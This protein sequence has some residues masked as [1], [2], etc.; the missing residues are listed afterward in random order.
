M[1][2][3]I[4]QEF[5]DS[6]LARVDIVDL[7]SE[8]IKLKRR[9]R[10]YV[11]CC[12]FHDEKTP[13]FTVSPEKQFYH[14]FGCG[15][16]GTAI[17]FLMNY[18]QLDFPAAVAELAG[19]FGLEIPRN[20]N[21]N[22]QEDTQRQAIY[23]LM[24]QASGFYQQQ[25]RQHP[26]RG[27]VVDYLKQRGL[28][29]E[30]AARFRLG[31][32]PPGWQN[33]YDVLTGSAS[34]TLLQQ[35]GLISIKEGGRCYD[36]FRDRVMFPIHDYRGR[37][38]AFGGRI[39]EQGEPKYL[40]SPE[41]EV[42]HKNRE[43]YGLY[44]ARRETRDLQRAIV[45]EGYMDVLALHQYGLTE[46]VAALGTAISSEHVKTLFRYVNEIVFCFDG[47]AAGEKAAWRALE[48]ALPLMHAG[49]QAKFMF[50]PEG[51]DPDSLLRQQGRAAFER[52][53]Q[54]A[55]PLSA[56]LFSR[57]QRD[58]DLSYADGRSKFVA[59]VKP[60]FK[61]LPAGV[62]RQMLIDEL[63]KL[64][65]MDS[66]VVE[67]AVEKAEF[68]APAAEKAVNS[69]QRH[70]LMPLTLVDKAILMLMQQPDL[71][72]DIAWQEKLKGVE[73]KTVA[74]LKSL[75]DLYCRD[76][77]LTSAQI[78]ERW[79]GSEMGAYFDYVCQHEREYEG[80]LESE[81]ADAIGR[82]EAKWREHRGKQLMR[83]ADQS[84]LS[85]EEKQELQALLS[86]AGRHDEKNLEN[87][88]GR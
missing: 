87:I 61:R 69:I 26:Q 41:T 28:S 39:M 81:F 78:S 74:V 6:L 79:Q 46:A 19:R 18:G 37:V 22:V 62:F 85:A 3:K 15:A 51:E 54:E 84:G 52:H 75:L 80:Q 43:L 34:D 55:M 8:R 88:Q 35:A 63:A 12:P 11:A 60:Y 77:Q 14:C 10:N 5:I 24:K 42:F 20:E 82:I 7:I 44:E 53:M 16:H 50:L 31:Y 4:P 25:L 32:A 49:R 56:Y 30:T 38:I 64:V 47:D 67:N 83:K 29:G 76:S 40:N 1:P 48:Q 86:P 13:S 73:G 45:V 36:R 2:G 59:L 65:A 33:L 70:P 23:A 58:V 68:A 17:R 9:G 66:V 71:A 27:Q 57:L 72:K 21:H